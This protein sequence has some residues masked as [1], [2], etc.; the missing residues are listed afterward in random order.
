MERR[1]TEG[2]RYRL[3]PG[4]DKRPPKPAYNLRRIGG[5]R[6]SPEVEAHNRET[7]ARIE[8]TLAFDDIVDSES[9]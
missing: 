2:D 9:P 7:M 1:R 8:T 3:S 4:A 5:V 6:L